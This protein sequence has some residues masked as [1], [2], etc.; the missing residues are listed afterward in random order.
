MEATSEV[1]CGR[2]DAKSALC[3]AIVMC[4]QCGYG[5]N[6]TVRLL[7]YDPTALQVSPD[8]GHVAFTMRQLG[9]QSEDNARAGI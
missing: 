5:R 2:G 8:N 1:A 6:C 7:S 9:F 4:W 3:R